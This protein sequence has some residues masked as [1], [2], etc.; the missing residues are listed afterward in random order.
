MAC[1]M[2]PKITDWAIWKARL[3][4]ETVQKGSI[5][6]ENS[7]VKVYNKPKTNDEASQGGI[8][9]IQLPCFPTST[10]CSCQY[11]QHVFFSKGPFKKHTDTSLNSSPVQIKVDF[12][13]IKETSLRSSDWEEARFAASQLRSFG[14]HDWKVVDFFPDMR[15]FFLLLPP[16]KLNEIR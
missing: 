1:Q 16:K 3:S 10:N 15:R 6:R 8:K 14:C 5:A 13:K 11:V 4:S 2:T 12:Q 9:L 7:F